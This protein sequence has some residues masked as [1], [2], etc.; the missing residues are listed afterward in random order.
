[1]KES[2]LISISLSLVAL[3]FLKGEGCGEEA[4]NTP[5]ASC[6]SSDRIS[7]LVA[8]GECLAIPASCSNSSVY[9]PDKHALTPKGFQE[10]WLSLSEND[11]GEYVLCVDDEAQL[12]LTSQLSL[13][14]E[15]KGPVMAAAKSLLIDV[16][17][18]GWDFEL[19]APLLEDRN[20]EVREQFRIQS[21]VLGRSGIVSFGFSSVH[22]SEN[23]CFRARVTPE[24]KKATLE[25]SDQDS[26][27]YWANVMATK[28]TAPGCHRITASVTP[29]GSTQ[30]RTAFMDFSVLPR[31]Q[32]VL[33]V[34][35]SQFSYFN[36]NVVL[37]SGASIPSQG[38]RSWMVRHKYPGEELEWQ[39]VEHYMEAD[40]VRFV[41]SEVHVGT[42]KIELTITDSQDPGLS[43]TVEMMIEAGY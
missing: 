26:E 18:L 23:P 36:T 29:A 28:D 17:V 9:R 42:Y 12:E 6:V 5:R 34:D 20:L 25:L 31:V 2:K 4:A 16:T 15:T 30:G 1:M 13:Q 32:A 39:S 3:V 11:S 19:E 41:I 35:A 22:I 21:I 14:I 40:G 33:D 8:R 10:E 7:M 27:I 24:S 43:D 37:D 38:L